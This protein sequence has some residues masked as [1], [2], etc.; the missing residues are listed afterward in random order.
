MASSPAVVVLGHDAFTP[1]PP[2]QNAGNPGI[3]A[4]C[5]A[6]RYPFEVLHPINIWFIRA[7]EDG[8][9]VP[10]PHLPEL[11]DELHSEEAPTSTFGWHLGRSFLYESS[12]L[13]GGR[14]DLA[15]GFEAKGQP[16][17]KHDAN[18]MFFLQ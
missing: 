15:Y 11:D 7:P 10:N 1:N 14:V 8:R 2:S 13:S 9:Y 5:K 17:E 3:A 4:E 16:L 18:T 12:G 6:L